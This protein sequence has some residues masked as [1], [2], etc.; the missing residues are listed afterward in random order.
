MVKKDFFSNEHL[1]LSDIS[2]HHSDSEISLRKYFLN[3]RKYPER[4]STY[5]NDEIQSELGKRIHELNLTSSLSLLAAIEAVFR[6]DYLQRNSKKK[7][8]ALSVACRNIYKEK[9]T[10]ASLEDDILNAWRLNTE[11]ANQ[12]ISDLKG[13]FKY[14]HWLAHGRYWKPQMGRPSYDYEAIY[15]LAEVVFDNFPFEGLNA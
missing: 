2:L 11:G 6:I 10:K 9:Q 7:K 8:D 5:T 15:E 14:R 12:L 3:A 1:D 13:A 4:F